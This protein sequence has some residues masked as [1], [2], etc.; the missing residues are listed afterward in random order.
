M[1]FLWWNIWFTFP[2]YS[3]NVRLNNPRL[4]LHMLQRENTICWYICCIKNASG[5]VFF[6]VFI[7]QS[8]PSDKTQ[9]LQHMC[10]QRLIKKSKDVLCLVI[11]LDLKQFCIYLKESENIWEVVC[12][13]LCRW[14]A[15]SV[16]IVNFNFQKCVRFGQY[17]LNNDKKR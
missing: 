17:I 5:C 1:T 12:F 10:T 4:V 8:S 3:I 7:I 11:L 15:H 9:Y 14:K 16:F 13:I 6:S 2:F